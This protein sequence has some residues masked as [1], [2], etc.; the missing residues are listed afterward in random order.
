[1]ANK[2]L[3]ITVKG[4]H[5]K[6]CF[7]VYADP[8]YLEEWQEDGLEIYE[9]CNVIPA[10]MPAPLISWYVI[11]QDAFNFNFREAWYGLRYKFTGKQEGG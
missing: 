8:K 9:V 10:W 2:R 6:W 4:K 3:T 7:D 1:M 5:K 11:A